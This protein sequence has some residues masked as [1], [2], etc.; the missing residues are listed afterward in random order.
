M[1]PKVWI[2]VRGGCVEDVQ[3]NLPGIDVEI[4]DLDQK[5]VG[6][7]FTNEFEATCVTPDG[8]Q[9]GTPLNDA[10]RECFHKEMAGNF[11]GSK[12][13]VE[14]LLHLISHT[15]AA[16]SAFRAWLADAEAETTAAQDPDEDTAEDVDAHGRDCDE[17]TEHEQTT[18]LA[19]IA[20][21][22]STDWSY[23]RRWKDEADSA[24]GLEFEDELVNS[25]GAHF[26]IWV[27]KS[28]PST[29]ATLIQKSVQALRRN[30]DVIS[31]S[32]DYIPA[33]VP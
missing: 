28:D 13:T 21:K 3:A 20:S 8:G 24:G 25:H 2:V 11:Q 14:V 18:L 4:S 30:R 10:E 7:P 1:R 12:T 6:D 22:R 9:P 29:E 32:W 17:E 5:G 16:A 19:A 23:E 27:P 15:P 26:H 31:W 33:E